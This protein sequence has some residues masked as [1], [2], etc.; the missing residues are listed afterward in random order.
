[1]DNAVLGVFPYVENLI[2]ATVRLK[3]S[4]YEFTL[5]S[6]VPLGH[7]LDHVIGAK[8]SG[9]KR[10]TFFGALFGF[11][12]GIQLV[13][14]TSAIYVLPRGGRAIWAMTPTLLISYETTILLGVLFTFLGFLVCAKLP[15]LKKRV[16]DPR[17]AIDSFGL[18]V[19][20]ISKDMF[21]DVENILK[22]FGANEVKRVEA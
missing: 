8:K 3:N 10:F 22:E 13:F 17:L 15:S 12:F 21:N 7:E 19:S 2:D 9:I 4:G 16:H 6:P 20:G 18:L 1:M 14:I 11:I 5:F